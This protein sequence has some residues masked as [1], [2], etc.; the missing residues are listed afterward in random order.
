MLKTYML[1]KLCLEEIR[2]QGFMVGIVYGPKGAG[3]SVYT[4]KVAAGIYKHLYGLSEEEA[5]R[6]ALNSL[7]FTLP[8]LLDVGEERK[9]VIWDDAGLW[10]STY[11]W[12]D[13]K[14]MKVIIA[15]LDYW[16]VIRTDMNVVLISTPSLM[17]LPPRIREDSSAVIVEAVRKGYYVDK[18]GRWKKTMMKGYVQREHAG[19]QKVI[20]EN[21]FIDWV[22]VKLPDKTYREYLKRRESYA[23][24][25]KKALT[26]KIEEIYGEE[27]NMYLK[28]K[29]FN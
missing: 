7:A 10:G 1:T 2:N 6:E 13:R 4:I 3:K 28:A 11:K 20:R 8:E 21:T 25:A 12:Y 23:K 5:Y 15:L 16:D 9:I 14:T 24:Y 19:W 29:T 18:D 27:I 26:K 22:K 17:K